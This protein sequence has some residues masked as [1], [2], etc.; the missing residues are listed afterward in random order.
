MKKITPALYH[1]HADPNHPLKDACFDTA[2]AILTEQLKSN[3][4]GLV[5][6]MHALFF[7]TLLSNAKAA[8]GLRTPNNTATIAVT[9]Q[10]FKAAGFSIDFTGFASHR[11]QQDHL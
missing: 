3:P 11:P 4:G 5:D 8:Q 9:H 6:L 10:I 7:A 2:T 1:L